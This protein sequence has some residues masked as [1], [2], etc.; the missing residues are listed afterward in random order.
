MMG[1]EKLRLKFHKVF[2]KA[3]HK[4]IERSRNTPLMTILFA[5]S[6]SLMLYQNCSPTAQSTSG[7]A[8]SATYSSTIGGFSGTTG[9]SGTS[10][11]AGSGSTGTGGG[12]ILVPG[13]SGGNGGTAGTGAGSGTI[14]VG[15]G[16]TGG[17]GTGSGGGNGVIPGGSTGGA[18]NTLLWQYQP[19]DRTVEEGEMLTLSSYAT[20]GIDTVTYQW[21][22]AGS[23][24]T[25]QTGYIYR[26]IL[27]PMS[28]AGQ[29]YV[30]AKSGAESIQSSVTMVKVKAARNACPAGSWGPYPGQNNPNEYWHESQIGKMNAPYSIPSELADAYTIRLNYTGFNALFPDCLSATASFQCRNGKLVMVDNVVCTRQREF[31]GA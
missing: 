17:S 29:Y 18:S 7:T 23:P 16:G 8:K 15:S 14:P 5:T 12:A 4:V 28:A 20:K 30:V 21:Y 10:G 19:E 31:G 22:R 25:G 9:T 26:A 11:T 6:T 3:F 2:H 1:R 27:V 24:I 13:G